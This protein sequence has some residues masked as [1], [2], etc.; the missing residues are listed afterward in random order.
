LRVSADT[1]GGTGEER[2]SFEAVVSTH[3]FDAGTN[4]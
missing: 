2:G 4:A 3:C 1:I